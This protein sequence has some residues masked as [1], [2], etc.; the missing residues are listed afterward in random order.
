[1]KKLPLLFIILAA[2]F[3]VACT[4]DS[5]DESSVIPPRSNAGTP[6][7]PGR[8]DAPRSANALVRQYYRC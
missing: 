2:A 1:M 4:N 5:T 6:H 3:T 7:R 8:T